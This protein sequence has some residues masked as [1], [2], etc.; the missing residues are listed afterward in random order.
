MCIA[1]IKS[2]S[3]TSAQQVIVENV[4]VTHAGYVAGDDGQAEEARETPA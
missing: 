1:L 3:L 2:I 4:A